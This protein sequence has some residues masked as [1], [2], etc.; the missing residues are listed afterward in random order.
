MK[1]RI[2]YTKKGTPGYLYKYAN[3][4][5]ELLVVLTDLNTEWIDFD[6]IEV[7]GRDCNICQTIT[8]KKREYGY[9]R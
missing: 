6:T 8:H 4:S 1:H 3:S 9:S 7:S 2:E 5:R